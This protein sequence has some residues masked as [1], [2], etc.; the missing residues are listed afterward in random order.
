MNNMNDNRD[1]QRLGRLLINRRV[2]LGYKRRVA[3][4]KAHGLSNDRSISAIENA[5]RQNFSP[6]TIASFELYYEWEP[7]S[8]DTVL[9]GGDPTP[10]EGATTQRATLAE[11]SDSELLL[12]L[13]RRL[14]EGQLAAARLAQLESLNDIAKLPPPTS[15]EERKRDDQ[16]HRSL[17][18]TAAFLARMPLLGDEHTTAVKALDDSR[19]QYIAK[20]GRAAYDALIAGHDV[21]AVVDQLMSDVPTLHANTSVEGHEP[22]LDAAA[23]DNGGP[24]AY[25]EIVEDLH[26]DDNN[27]R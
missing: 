10:R 13:A 6:A 7:G 23:D 11:Y 26:G 24:S 19:D 27:G 21:E 9:A 4:A 1:W 17:R 14:T 18:E 16:A 25:E 20:H 2:E 5:E 8:I 22:P 3:F 12:D 15:D